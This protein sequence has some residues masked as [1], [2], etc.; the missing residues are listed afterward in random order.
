MIE[1]ACFLCVFF[2]SEKHSFKTFQKKGGENPIFLKIQSKSLAEAKPTN[3]KKLHSFS[4][5]TNIQIEWINLVGH[6]KTSELRKKIVTN[7]RHAPFFQ[8]T[9]HALMKGDEKAIGVRGVWGT[10]VGI[11]R[12]QAWAGGVAGS[13]GSL[14]GFQL[15]TT[16]EQRWRLT[17]LTF[18][19]VPSLSHL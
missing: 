16:A 8:I 12:S 3:G 13:R 10:L 19:P 18:L 5:G 6:R 17:D 9:P 1:E 2:L 4:Y 15:N 14:P 7:D 11:L